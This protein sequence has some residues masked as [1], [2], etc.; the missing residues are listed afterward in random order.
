VR[1]VIT[2]E[3]PAPT[4]RCEQLAAG[5]RMSRT[6]RARSSW[7]SWARVKVSEQLSNWSTKIAAGWYRGRTGSRLRPRAAARDAPHSAPPAP[8]PSALA[9]VRLRPP[10][11]RRYGV[12]PGRDRIVA[13]RLAP[14]T[15]RCVKR[16][17]AGAGSARCLAA[18]SRRAHRVP[19][20]QAP[21]WQLRQQPGADQARLAEPEARSLP[22]RP[23]A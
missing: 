14:S 6:S 2:N 8:A 20:P 19:V 22:D 7:R 13:Q 12:G 21:T 16:A 17:R 10:R 11:H 1:I 3:K 18:R 9:S 15:S 4:A 23:R 5:P